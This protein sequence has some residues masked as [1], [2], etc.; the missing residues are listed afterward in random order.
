MLQ[1][2][3]TKLIN[4]L[5]DGKCDAAMC[6][7]DVFATLIFIVNPR[8]NILYA[9]LPGPYFFEAAFMAV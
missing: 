8:M 2:R 1:T 4:K 5:C 6:F 3:S 9:R 7:E